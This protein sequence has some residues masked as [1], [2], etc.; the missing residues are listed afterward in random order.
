MPYAKRVSAAVLLAALPMFLFATVGSAN[1]AE[2]ETLPPAVVEQPRVDRLIVKLREPRA[3]S[4]AGNAARP[5]VVNSAEVSAAMLQ[6]VVERV[7]RAERLSPQGA[8]AGPRTR[9]AANAVGY[10]RAMS[11]AAHVVGLAAAV[12]AVDAAAMAERLQAQPEVEY[13]EPDYRLRAHVEPTDPLYPQQWGYHEMGAGANLTAAWD[14]TTGSANVAAA[15][16]DSGYRMHPDLAANLLPGYD[17]ISDPFSANDGDGRDSDASDPG[18]WATFEDSLQCDGTLSWVANSTWHGTHVAGTIGAVANNGVGGVGVSWQGRIV[19]VRVLG[20]CGGLVSDIVDAI[21]WAAGLP[22]PGVPGNPYPAKVINLS[23]GMSRPC[24]S[25]MQAAIDD[26]IQQGASVVASAGNGDGDVAEPANCDGAIAVAAVGRRGGKAPLS[27]FG[28][29]VDIGAPGV[30]ILS[31]ANAGKTT[32]AEDNYLSYSGTSM[33]A[34][35]VTG[36]IG[37][38]LAA[39]PALTPDAIRAKL[40]ASARRY[41]AGSDCAEAV[42]GSVCG[43]GMLDARRALEDSRLVGSGGESRAGERPRLSAAGSVPGE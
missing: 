33:A 20:K 31:T 30:G 36:T 39:N 5:A 26:V 27:N 17:F 23:L 37:L 8:G 4:I 18:N 40:I 13:A 16:I 1:A 22:V 41:P 35:H 11:G 15:V 32:P 21:R 6:R 28:P 14:A 9:R 19:P 3:A 38:M 10:T 2:N 24:T 34:P 29:R 25:A 12:D 43:S 42:T 7:L